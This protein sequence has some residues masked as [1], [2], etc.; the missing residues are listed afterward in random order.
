MIISLSR[1]P[2]MICLQPSTRV[3][4]ALSQQAVTEFKLTSILPYRGRK[5]SVI[6]TTRPAMRSA[7]YSYCFPALWI[8]TFAFL[9][10]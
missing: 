9:L 5:S 1:S 7:S 4:N 10:S 8:A 2:K 3:S 6:S